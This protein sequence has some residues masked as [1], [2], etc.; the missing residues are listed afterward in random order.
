MYFLSNA[1]IA[2]TYSIP[3]E[4]VLYEEML[5]STTHSAVCLDPTVLVVQGVDT[6][7]ARI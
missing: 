7:L 2:M 3:L 1:H 5:H 4:M 6:F